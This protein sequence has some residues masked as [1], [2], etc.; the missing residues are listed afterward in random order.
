MNGIEGAMRRRLLAGFVVFAGLSWIGALSADASD[1]MFRRSYYSHSAGPGA[2]EES[3]PSRTAYREPW[4]G[5][6]PRFAIRGGCRFNSFVLQNRTN[7]TDNTSF[8]K[9]RDAA[10]Y[11]C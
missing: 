3:A 7:R 9:N 1:W 11:Q 10:N 6:H 2:M 5:A 4:V 8:P